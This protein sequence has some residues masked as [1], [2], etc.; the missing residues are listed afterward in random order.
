MKFGLRIWE[1]YS[2]RD[3]ESFNYK[4]VEKLYNIQEIVV[5]EKGFYHE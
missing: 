2:I 1:K 4:S 3:V 5:Y